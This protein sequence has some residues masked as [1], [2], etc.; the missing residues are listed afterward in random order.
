L[1]STGVDS[2]ISLHQV[3]HSAELCRCICPSPREDTTYCN[4]EPCQTSLQGR[5]RQVRSALENAK[6]AVGSKKSDAKKLEDYAFHKGPKEYNVY[7]DVRKGLIPI[8]GAAR[9]TGRFS[10]S[11]ATLH[12]GRPPPPPRLVFQLC[13]NLAS[14]EGQA[15]AFL[16]PHFLRAPLPP[17][18]CSLLCSLQQGLCG[19]HLHC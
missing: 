8:V 12:Q 7:W 19:L 13:R 4:T 9:E 17:P 15:E 11:V 10:N 14:R 1:V 6:L 18:S 16:P 5:I 2:H 3:G